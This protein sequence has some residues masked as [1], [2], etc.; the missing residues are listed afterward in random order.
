VAMMTA[1][2]RTTTTKQLSGA[3]GGVRA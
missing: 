1:T 3:L 2:K